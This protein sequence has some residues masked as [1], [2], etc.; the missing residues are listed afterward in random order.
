MVDVETTAITASFVIWHCVLLFFVL[1][2]I[3]HLLNFYVLTRRKLRSSPCTLYFLAATAAACVVVWIM[4]PWRFLQ[5]AYNIEPAYYSSAICKIEYYLN[6]TTRAMAS[7][8]L[9]LACMDR[10]FCSSSNARMRRFSSVRM[11]R[12]III[13]FTLTMFIIHIHVPIYNIVG[14]GRTPVPFSQV[15]T[16]CTITTGFYATFSLYWFFIVYAFSP[17]VI[18]LIFGLLTLFNIH[19]RRRQ[20]LPNAS[21]INNR[22]REKTSRQMLIMLIVQCTF[23]TICTMPTALQRFYTYFTSTQQKSTTQKALDQ[24]FLTTTLALGFI[25]HSLTFYMFTL[26]GSMFR[27][28]VKQLI[29]KIPGCRRILATTRTQTTTNGMLPVSHEQRNMA[30]LRNHQTTRVTT[31]API[32]E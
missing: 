18:M 6:N 11:A 7:W 23:I 32:N 26:S 1:G 10:Y 28:E 9:G 4:L 27:D 15:S 30:T 31:N 25:G 14:T 29:T 12:I 3:G 21:D 8:F 19:Q 22:K 20:I 5:Y 17:P 16:I 2:I 24:L 13:I